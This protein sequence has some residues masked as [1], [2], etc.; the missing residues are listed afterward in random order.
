M[1]RMIR[2]DA[3][4]G[5]HVPFVEGISFCYDRRMTPRQPS[6]WG[7]RVAVLLPVMAL[8]GVLGWATLRHQQ[9]L[10]IGAALA[11][12]QTP[13]MPGVVLPAFDGRRVSLMDLRGHAVVFNFWASWCIP[14]AEEAPILEELWETSRARGLVVVGVDTQ[15]LEAPARRFLAQ[16][17]ITYLNLRD[18]DGSLARLFGATGVPETFFVGRDG[19][20]RGKIPGEIDR[21]A[22]RAAVDALLAGNA[23][24]P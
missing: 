20:I 19:L 2:A 14:C 3:G 1:L 4:E 21:T 11:R 18:P 5:V 7:T 17:G 16:H 10:A 23:Q 13:P 24:V 9:S 15:D 6:S 8:L 22:W 12:G